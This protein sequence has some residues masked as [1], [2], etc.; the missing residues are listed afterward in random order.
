MG[1]KDSTAQSGT[2][3]SSSSPDN[4]SAENKAP[5][6]G[7][8]PVSLHV[9]EPTQGSVQ[10]PGFGVY[11]T[12]VEVWGTEYVFAGPCSNSWNS[13]SVR[14]CLNMQEVQHLQVESHRNDQNTCRGIHHEDTLS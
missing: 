6:S 1:N 12:G 5:S 9:Y 7:G 11:H 10:M 13:C 4:K 3:S 8:Q 14:A 2:A